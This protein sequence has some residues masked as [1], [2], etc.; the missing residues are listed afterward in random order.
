M[1]TGFSENSVFS[2]FHSDASDLFNVCSSL[3]K[4]R[5]WVSGWVGNVHRCVIG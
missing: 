1:K 4:V 3:E 2:V 5:R